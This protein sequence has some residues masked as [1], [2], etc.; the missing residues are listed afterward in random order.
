MYNLDALD[1]LKRQPEFK[2]C[3]NCLDLGT[4]WRLTH[5]G[6]RVWLR[7][8][9]CDCYA[10][11]GFWGTSQGPGLEPVFQDDLP[12]LNPQ[13]PNVVNTHGR[14]IAETYARQGDIPVDHLEYCQGILALNLDNLAVIANSLAEVL[15]ERAGG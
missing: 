1:W 11:R 12:P 8:G 6:Q 7:P 10:G 15:P 4:L 5:R 3:R 14:W 9:P 13:D 2:D